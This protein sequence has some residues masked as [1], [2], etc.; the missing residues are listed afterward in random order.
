MPSLFA[1]RLVLFTLASACA[2]PLYAFRC[3]FTLVKDSCWKDFDVTVAVKEVRTDKPLFSLSV[4]KGESWSRKEFACEAGA[5]IIY[6]ATFSPSIWKGSEGKTYLAQ[7][8]WS[9]PTAIK[10][11]ETAWE[12]PV[13]FPGAFA[14][15]PLPAT[16]GSNCACNF[17][18]VPAIPATKVP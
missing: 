4:A 10:A 13:C 14:E 11:G 17:D 7:R 2:L 1:K 15:V 12:I 3:V 8:F 6:S 9:L 18:A 16:A 5:E